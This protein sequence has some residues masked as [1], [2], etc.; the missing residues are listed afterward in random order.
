MLPTLLAIALLHWAVL[1]TPGANVLVV[2]HL[3]ASGQRKAACSAAVGVTTVAGIWSALAV[4]GIGAVFA[5]HPYLRI[6]VQVAGGLYLLHVAVRLWCSQG[7]APLQSALR[8][9]PLAAFR[10]GFLTNILNPKSAL[11]FG[12]VFATALPAEPTAALL[13]ASVGVVLAN[14]LAW[15]LLLAFAFAT[16]PVQ[17]AY[18]RQRDLLN[19]IASLLVG[20][21]GM[22]LLAATGQE[23][24]GT[25]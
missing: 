25:P 6:A 10:L 13:A 16:A 9:S 22:R 3:A 24:R 4:L 14:A 15:H 20:A 2:T 19:R 7:G 5:A 1:A 11:F 8:L 17:A 18:A 12:S 21:F 23:L